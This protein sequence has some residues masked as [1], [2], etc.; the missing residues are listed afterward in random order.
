MAE[1]A[2]QMLTV[3]LRKVPGRESLN[4]NYRIAQ[5]GK[6]FKRSSGPISHMKRKPG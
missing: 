5:A 6:D 2:I 3:A 1:G 4:W